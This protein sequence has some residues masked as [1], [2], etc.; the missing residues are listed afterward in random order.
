[1]PIYEYCCND[2][3]PF[4]RMRPMAECELPS[5]CSK[6]GAAAPRVILTAPHRSTLSA[7]SR[8][9]HATNERSA[10]A[11]RTLS[12]LKASHNAGCACC[13]GRSSRLVGRGKGG[14]KTFP[15]SRPWMICH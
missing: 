2:C 12:S 11:P 15:M 10:H 14:S 5:E 7:K 1:M 13:S 4:T 6:C 9:A 8:L 3:G